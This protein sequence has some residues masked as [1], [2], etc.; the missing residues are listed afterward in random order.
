MLMRPNL[1]IRDMVDLYLLLLTAPDE[2]VAGRD[3]QRRVP[4]LHGRADR[5]GRPGRGPAGTA[6]RGEIEI[7]TTPSDDIRSYHLTRTR[8]AGSSGSS[9]GGPSR[10]APPTWS[11]RSAPACSPAR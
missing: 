9:R 4:E 5:G 11:G 1:H 6:R 2:K 7:V 3:V 10:T 8:S